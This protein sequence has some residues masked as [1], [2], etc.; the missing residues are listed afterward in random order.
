MHNT[1]MI[2]GLAYPITVEN[3]VAWQQ[4]RTPEM[5]FEEDEIELIARFIPILNEAGTCTEERFLR[6]AREMKQTA[7]QLS[8][9]GR[10]F[11]MTMLAWLVTV[12]D[13]IKET[14]QDKEN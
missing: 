12:H 14:K 10:G 3:F 1:Y 2:N 4:S 13:T 6:I 11:M 9:A 8:G 5:T 7:D